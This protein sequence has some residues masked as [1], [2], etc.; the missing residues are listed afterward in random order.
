KKRVPAVRIEKGNLILREGD[1]VTSEHIQILRDLALIDNQGNRILIFVSL[2]LFS[3][4]LIGIG[5]FYIYRFKSEILR[6][7]NYLYLLALVALV[8]LATAKIM[9]LLDVMWL[10]YM[11]PLS[12]AGIILTILLD[13][14][15]AWVAT[16]LL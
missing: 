15:I 5:V 13:P 6:Q 14:Q 3:L 9:S 1:I 12:F 7:E 2:S 16:T 11:I 4:F 10:R 8:V